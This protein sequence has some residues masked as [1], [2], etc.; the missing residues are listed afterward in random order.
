[1]LISS[2]KNKNCKYSIVDNGDCGCN[3]V[4]RYL[5]TSNGFPV[6]FVC[7]L[8]FED[9]NEMMTTFIDRHGWGHG[10][11]EMHLRDGETPRAEDLDI[12]D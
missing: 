8:M 11:C 12:A 7:R 5:L 4:N 1:M 2:H 6:G 9:S 10:I 3:C